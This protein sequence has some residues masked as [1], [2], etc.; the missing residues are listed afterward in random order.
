MSRISVQVITKL[1]TYLYLNLNAVQKMVFSKLYIGFIK[2]FCDKV[3]G[4]KENA[5]VNR[6]FLKSGKKT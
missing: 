5:L 3:K 2:M 4:S 1:G 6:H